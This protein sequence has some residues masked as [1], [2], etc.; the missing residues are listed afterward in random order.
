M[1][2]IFY[3]FLFTVSGFSQSLKFKTLT[4][5]DGL[6]NNSVNDIIGDNKGRLWIATWDGLNR[7]DSKDFKSYKHIDNDSTSLAGNVIYVLQKDGDGKIWCL[8]DNNT[9]SRLSEKGTFE[10]YSFN[11]DPVDLQLSKDNNLVVVTENGR[12]YKFNNTGFSEMEPEQVNAPGSAL[13]EKLLQNQYPDV[14]INEAYQ[15]RKGNIWYA[16][17][18][19]GLFVIRNKEVNIHNMHIE[20]YVYDLYNPY[21]L[22]GNEIEKIYEDDFGNIWLGHK[23]GGLSMAFTGSE[24][25]NTIAPHPET[26][27]QLPGETVRAVTM[28]KNNELWLGYYTRGLYK[29]NKDQRDFV[30]A[31]LKR[32]ETNKDWERI[33]SLYTGK[34]GSVWVGTY[35]GLVRIKEKDTACYSA[36]DNPLLPAN[37]IY[38]VTETKNNKLWVACWGGV[39]LFDVKENKFE[40]FKGR[41]KLKS[42]HIRDIVT[43]GNELALATEDHGVIL[44]NPNNGSKRH[45]TT[46]QGLSGNSIYDIH[47][48]QSSGYYWIAAL[49]GVTVF[50]PQKGVVK[51]IS[52][53]EG[54]PS[55][56]VYSVIPNGRHIWISTTKGIAAI[57]KDNYKVNVLNPEEGWQAPEFSEGAYYQD[58]KGVLYFGGINGLNYFAPELIGFN[59]TLPALTFEI[60]GMNN[61]KMYIEKSYAEN[62]ISL[63]IVPVSYRKNFEN[64]V[65]YRLTG[66]DKDWKVFKGNPVLYKDLSPGVYTLELKNSTSNSGMP[67]SQVKVIISP[68]FYKSSWFVWVL[69]TGGLLFVTFGF[70]YKIRKD[71]IYK[72]KLRAKINERTAVI[73]SQKKDLIEVN[74][75]LEDQNRKIYRQKEEVLALHHQL[76][77]EDFEIEKFKTFVLAGFKKPL[78]QILQ[79]SQ[80]D[81]IPSEVQTSLVHQT[82]IM[83]D[84]LIEWDFLAQVNH[85]D[86]SEKSLVKVNT[87]LID[88][89][90]N[91]EQQLLKSGINLSYQIHVGE[92]WVTIDLLQFKLL[93]KYLFNDLIK[94]SNRG[95]NICLACF[96]KDEKLVLHINS[97]SELLQE[98]TEGLKRYSPYYNAVKKLLLQL[99]GNIAVKTS[100]EAGVTMVLEVPC[101]VSKP[102]KDSVIQWNHLGMIDEL[103]NDKQNILILSKEVNYK[104][105]ESLLNGEGYHLIFENSIEKITSAFANLNIDLLVMY[106]VKLNGEILQFLEEQKKTKKSARCPILFI[107]E[108][109]GYFQMEQATELGIDTA[110]QLPVSKSFIQAKFTNLLRGR[111]ALLEEKSSLTWFAKHKEDQL[112]S[113]NEKLVKKGLSCM[114]E[115]MHDHTFNIERLQEKLEISRVKCYR[116]FKE[117]LNQSPSDVLINLRMQKAQYLLDQ[118]TLNISEISFECGFANPKY[119][120]RQFKK[121]FNC[122]PKVYK[123]QKKPA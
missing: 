10:N 77:N 122:S 33:R 123:D 34:D 35:A 15:D 44:F 45:L 110:I 112:L 30:K 113:P 83:M 103:P 107:S 13:Y 88:L 11:E 5:K 41:E 12:Y 25:I 76:K 64:E 14:F 71:K 81:S 118:N 39:A 62:H 55:H 52:E 80:D 92:A 60:D 50:D 82:R 90:K 117:V 87:V 18:K 28:D 121:H 111:K 7:Y 78:M 102:G 91:Q 56:M 4:T 105:L 37:R 57:Y 73:D 119:F 70:L 47:K 21:S 66:L 51:V 24:H 6:S 1:R 89:T 67:E 93:F 115:S 100:K 59:K 68:P 48:D 49:G 43:S 17:R 86:V 79:Q 75:V 96:L 72:E 109:I 63:N 40:D 46:A 98:N 27:R 108:E 95:S 85:I 94:Y 84:A 2:L 22:A 31:P 74:K 19:S 32:A 116:V 36:E 106:D 53:K 42:Y 104:I 29:Y 99:A 120:S 8:T 9:V 23:D 16:T 114:H 38:A 101:S 54:L 20:H 61:D 26:F 69:V 58:A 3:F 97:D 65:L